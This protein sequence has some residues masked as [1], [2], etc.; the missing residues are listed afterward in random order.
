MN[1]LEVEKEGLLKFKQGLTDPSG[2]LSSWVGE[3]CCKWRGVSCYNR[4]GRV[5]KLKLGN[6]FPNSLEGDRTASEL[7]GEINPSLLSL[8]YLNYLDLS[9]NN[10][11]GMEIPKFIGSLRKLRYLNLSGASFGGII[12][13]NIANLSNLRYLDLNTYSIEP[14]KNGL[15]WLSGLSSLKYLNLGGID[16]SKAAAYWLQT[17]N[18][19]PSLLELHMP[20]CQLSNL[21]LSLPFLNFTSLSILDLSNNGFDSTIPHWL[22][23]LSSLVYLDLNSNNLQGGL[24]DAFQN[25]TSLQLLDL[26]KNSN[27]EGELPRTLGNLC[28]LRTLILSVNKLSG[29]IAEFLD[30]LSACSYSTLEN[31]DLGFNK[32]TGNLPD[33]LGHLKN[34]RYLQLWSNSFRGSIPESIGSLSSLQELYLSQNQMGGIIPDSLGQLSSL[35]VLELNENSW[36][37][38]ITEAHFANLSS[39]KQLSITK[40]S[41]NV[42]LVFNISSDWAPPFKL[43]YINLRSC[44]LGPKFPTWLRTQNELTTIVLNN[45]GISGTIPD[46]LWKLDLQLSELDIAYNQLSGRVPNSLVFSYLANVDLSS[47]LFDGPLPL[48]SSNVSTLYLRGNLFSGPIPQNIGQVMPILTDLDISWNSLNG[49]IPLSMGD[50]QALITLVI[51]NNNLSGEIPQFWNKMPS[52]YIVDMS[53]NS[54]SGTIP[55]S[56]GSLT[57]LRFLV[58]SNNNLSGELPSQLQNCSVL[59]SLDLGDNK[60]SGNIPSW[61]GESMPSLLILALQSNFFSGNIPSEICA[62]SALHILDLSHNHVS[63]FIPPCFGNLSGF[64]SELSDDDLERYEGRLK[65]VAKG[66][67]LEYYSTLYLV[68]SLDL[69]NNSLSGEIPIELTS[70][71]KLGTLNLSSNNLG[72]NIPE[73]IGNLQWLET[74]DL[75]KNKLSGPIPMSMASITFLV[76][77]NLAHNNLSGKIPTGNQFQTLIDPSIYQGNLALCGF[78]LTTECHDNNGTIPTGK[79]EDNDDEDG[80]DS[81]LPWFFVSMGLGFIIGFW[82]VCG[83][84]IIKT[85]WRYAYFRFVEKMKDRLLLAVALNVARLTR[86]V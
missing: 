59:E 69:S 52:L 49:S 48:W 37:G 34:L 53:N 72:G 8:K 4:T 15:E 64:K 22:F 67:A 32:L 44:Q 51:S 75:S 5:I 61:I 24:P 7:G 1:C 10:F 13:P 33:S 29:E 74:L 35:V 71:L 85:S 26:S 28:Y 86:K 39:L 40:S 21:S 45:A 2:R 84:L 6:P 62:L 54:L 14:N 76:H 66:R 60:F 12:P 17:V 68:N 19:L 20:N 79:G 42:S 36:E 38:V 56:L 81:E 57:A 47:N 27:I 83:T 58:L 82:G 25:F 16:L 41:P 11:E 55:R 23:N 65:L 63:G 43:T 3:D 30:G 46:W 77:L 80:D 18:T 9:K 50:L 73:K 78:P 31:L 70:L